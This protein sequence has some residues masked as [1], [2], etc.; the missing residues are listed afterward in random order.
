MAAA[1]GSHA[2]WAMTDSTGN[3]QNMK[4]NAWQVSEQNLMECCWSEYDSNGCGGGGVSGPMQCAVD[5]G[6]LPSTTTHPYFAT[7]ENK[8]CLHS[9]TEGAA[10]VSAWYEPCSN[11]DETCLKT[12]IGGNNCDTFAT[13]ALKTSIEVISSFYDYADGIYSDPACPN[14]IHNHAVAIVGWGTDLTT[15]QD[16]WIIRNSW[17]PEWGLDGYLYMARG[18]NMCCV[19]CEN[20]FFQ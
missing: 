7:T 3:P 14:T 6:S 18:S 1:E 2:L 5:M 16:Y 4:N 9:K 20:L 12:L 11:G 13:I 10:Y 17:G 8:T 15:K 19:A